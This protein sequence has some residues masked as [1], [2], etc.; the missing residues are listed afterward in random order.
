MHVPQKI[1]TNLQTYI[2]NDSCIYSLTQ[3][4][5]STRRR[6]FGIGNLEFLGLLYS[7]NFGRSI[8]KNIEI[9]GPKTLH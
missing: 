6:S 1:G 4:L 9:K 3:S 7:V 8:G 2:E 5:V